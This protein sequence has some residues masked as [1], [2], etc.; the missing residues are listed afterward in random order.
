MLTNIYNVGLEKR[1]E[2]KIYKLTIF[3]VFIIS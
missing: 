2:K 3:L 1:I